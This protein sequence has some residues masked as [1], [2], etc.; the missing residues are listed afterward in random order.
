MV[1]VFGVI[2]PITAAIVLVV[3]LLLFGPGKLPSIGK[4]IGQGIREF[5][6]ASDSPDKEQSPAET[7]Q[8]AGTVQ[9]AAEEKVSDN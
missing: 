3:V 9:V 6:K 5:K 8:P 4:A 1:S 7:N 2:T